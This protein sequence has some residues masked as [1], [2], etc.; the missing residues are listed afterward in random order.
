MVLNYIISLILAPLIAA[1]IIAIVWIKRDK[2]RYPQLVSSFILGMISI[3]VVV[4]FMYVADKYYLNAF[5]NLRREIFYSFIVMG[6]GS[7]LGKFIILRYHNFNKS[8]FNGPLDGIVH[9]VMI[10]MGFAF[11]G[12]ILYFLLPYY[13]EIDFLYAITV[14]FANLF[15]AVILGFFVGLA[16]TR[17]NKFVDS[18]TGLLAASF[19]HALYNFCFITEDIRLLLF[20][21]I[22][23]FIVVIMLYYKAYEMNQDHKRIKKD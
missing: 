4:L 13:T 20:F 1:I 17:E 3:V 6:I 15:F 2:Y 19:F 14:V 7:E 9:S 21:G 5:R 16:K 23:A 8:S 22:G 12:N 18:M 10:S 11:I